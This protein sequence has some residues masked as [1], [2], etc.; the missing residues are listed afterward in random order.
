MEWQFADDRP[1]YL[2]LVEQMR[3]IIVTGSW[4]PG[5]RLASVRD[6]A[7]EA[8]VNPNT[9][10]RALAELE[11]EGLVMA[12]RTSGRYVTE[13]TELVAKLR[14]TLAREITKNFKSSMYAIGCDDA[15]IETLVKEDLE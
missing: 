13:D 7:L 14:H 4:P 5:S 2:Q 9:M 10:Q 11:N 6:L 3:R 1:L 15:E 8:G 12:Q